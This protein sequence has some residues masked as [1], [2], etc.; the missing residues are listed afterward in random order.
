MRACAS[1]LTLIMGELVLPIGDDVGD[2]L[3]AR[4]LPLLRRAMSDRWG[5][6]T[7]RSSCMA[8]HMSLSFGDTSRSSS[9]GPPPESPVR[10][11]FLL[12]TG[13]AAGSFVQSALAASSFSA[14]AVS[15]SVATF[16][17]SDLV[18]VVVVSSG[19]GAGVFGLNLSFSSFFLVASEIVDGVLSSLF[20]TGVLYDLC[21]GPL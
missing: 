9:S 1:F 13:V 15:G 16:R 4:F 10:S 12:A 3:L 8:A 7:S 21:Q 6:I 19:C 17:C 14:P 5:Y 20:L 18:V 11:Q 2:E